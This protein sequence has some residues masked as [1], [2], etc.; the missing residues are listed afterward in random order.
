MARHRRSRAAAPVTSVVVN[1]YEVLGVPMG[2]DPAE[3]RRAYLRLAR[4]HHPDLHVADPPA[5]Q[6]KARRKMLEANA[7]W[8]VLGDRERRRDYDQLVIQGRGASGASGAAPVGRDARVRPQDPPRRGWAPHARD[9]RWMNDFE[10]WKAEADALPPDPPVP[11]GASEPWKVL[12]MGV[13]LASVALG[14]FAMVSNARA[15]LAAAYIGVAISAFLFFAVP[16]LTMTRRR[17]DG[18]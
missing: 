6:A 4:R 9:T 11:G 18:D 17:R 8:A 5:D 12:P 15:L 3:I 14:C 2:A 10:G 7:A 13:F 16:L 1:H